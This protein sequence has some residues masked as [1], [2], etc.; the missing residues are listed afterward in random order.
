MYIPVD[1]AINTGE[2]LC[3]LRRERLHS[4]TERVQ[5]RHDARAALEITRPDALR[6]IPHRH[7]RR[8]Q[9]VNLRHSVLRVVNQGLEGTCDAGDL[10]EI[11]GGAWGCGLDEGL[12]GGDGEEE[13]DDGCE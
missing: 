10:D 6:Q 12:E 1:I 13:G 7:A 8:L 9:I 4:I 3:H 11:A 2:E 5:I